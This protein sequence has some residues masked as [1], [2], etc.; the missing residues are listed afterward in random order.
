MHSK[1]FIMENELRRVAI[2]TMKEGGMNALQIANSLGIAVKTVWNNL[3]TPPKKEYHF[4]VSLTVTEHNMQN[5]RAKL[6]KMLGKS[7]VKVSD[8]INY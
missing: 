2:R 7:Y 5:A 4:Q 3:D 6:N 8:I 1:K